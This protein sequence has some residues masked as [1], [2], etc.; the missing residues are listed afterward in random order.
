MLQY[1]DPLKEV[2]I[3]KTTKKKKTYIKMSNP[4]LERLWHGQYFH[5]SQQKSLCPM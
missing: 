5:I 4:S 2:F 3:M 1:L